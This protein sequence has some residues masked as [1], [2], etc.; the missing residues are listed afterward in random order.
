MI[1]AIILLGFFSVLFSGIA[2]AMSGANK[3]TLTHFV[4]YA[5][6]LIILAM[7]AWIEATMAGSN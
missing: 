6:T 4:V 7:A 5:S 3:A 2:W 1:T